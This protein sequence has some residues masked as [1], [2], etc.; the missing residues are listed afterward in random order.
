M[1][2][3][4]AAINRGRG[5][6]AVSVSGGSSVEDNNL[7]VCVSYQHGGVWFYVSPTQYKPNNVSGA[8]A[9]GIMTLMSSP[10]EPDLLY[11]QGFC[12][13]DPTITP[14]KSRK[15]KT[16]MMVS[17]GKTDQFYDAQSM[18][19]RQFDCLAV[20]R[21]LYIGDSRNKTPRRAHVRMYGTRDHDFLTRH[22]LGGAADTNKAYLVYMPELSPFDRL[23][24]DDAV[25]TESAVLLNPWPDQQI[26]SKHFWQATG[27]TSASV[28]RYDNGSTDADK[29]WYA[30]SMFDKRV[31]FKSSTCQFAR[32]AIYKKI[33][34]VSGPSIRITSISVGTNRAAVGTRK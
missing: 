22:S 4:T 23:S 15:Y 28:G 13:V 24:Q 20:T 1:K 17:N 26:G 11:A 21:R 34:S 16:C 25:T 6:Y 2:W 33:D 27:A 3:A 19:E 7:T 18:S 30:S 14:P 32:F 9:A 31:D 8:A 5:F 10:R 29:Y 12:V